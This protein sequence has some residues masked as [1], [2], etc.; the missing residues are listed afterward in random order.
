MLAAAATN[1]LDLIKTRLQTQGQ[2][3][4]GQGGGGG[5]ADSLSRHAAQTVRYDGLLDAVQKIYRAEGAGAFIK[6]L[7]PRVVFHM[8]SMAICWTTY[9][10]VKH[11]LL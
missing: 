1:P 8:P 11:F 2:L 6:G 7:V 3:L 4:G 5:T 9:E 10:G